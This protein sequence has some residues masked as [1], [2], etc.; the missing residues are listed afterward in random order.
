MQIDHLV[1]AVKDLHEGM[2]RIADLTGV[3]PV[4]GGRHQGW[5]TWNALLSLGRNTYLEIIAPDPGQP[6]PELPRVLGVDAIA[7]PRLTRWAA[8]TGDL[9]GLENSAR[10][11][12]FTLGKII[13]GQ[14]Q[15][16]DGTVLQWRNSD[17]R[18][19]PG[20]GIV[21]FFIDWK[22]SVHPAVSSPAGCE[23]LE[24]WAE[25]PEPAGLQAKL[26]ALG[27]NLTVTQAAQPA[28]IAKIRTPRGI[29][30]L[31]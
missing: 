23:L 20:D 9:A 13:E 4:I 31:K 18:T 24:F 3:E 7:E 8:G 11:H 15:K 26:N 6:D 29:M 22:N 5:G 1:Y 19:D 12:G 10:E 16:P 30:M 28:L 21:P 25:H 2:R 27:L 17:P 14:R